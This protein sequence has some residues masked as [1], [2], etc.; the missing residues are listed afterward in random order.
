MQF[1]VQRDTLLKSLNFVQG[2]VEKKYI[3]DSFKCHDS[4]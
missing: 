4:T 1:I 3:A 2:V